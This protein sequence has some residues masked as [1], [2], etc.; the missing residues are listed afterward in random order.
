MVLSRNDFGGCGLET[1]DVTSV[2]LEE[3]APTSA[4]ITVA[5]GNRTVT[6]QAQNAGES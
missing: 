4:I 5:P 1:V 2:F 6:T 3:T